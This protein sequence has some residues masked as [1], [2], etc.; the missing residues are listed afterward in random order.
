M[1][2]SMM[3]SGKIAF[4]TVKALGLT[5]TDHLSLY[6]GIMVFT[7]QK[8]CLTLHQCGLND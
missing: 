4:R 6:L 1:D 5:K 7:N 8:A 2:E 3:E